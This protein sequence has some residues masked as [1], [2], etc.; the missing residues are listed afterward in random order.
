MRYSPGEHIHRVVSRGPLLILFLLLLA[1]PHADI[2]VSAHNL[3]SIPSSGSR[4]DLGSSRPP[5]GLVYLR[6]PKKSSGN[7]LGSTSANSS[8][9]RPVLAFYYPWYNKKDWC[10][11]HMSDLPTIQYTSSDNATIERQLQWAKQAS[12][13]GFI[14]SWW[15]P[16]DNTDKNF[17]K[18][19]QDAILLKASTGYAFTSSLYI[20]SDAPAL[21][22]QAKM[23]AGL[24]YIQEKYSNKSLFFHWQTKPVIFFWNPLGNG[25]SLKFWEDIRRQVD[26]QHKMLW[27]AEGVDMKLL[28]VFDGIHLFSAGYWGILHHTMK[29]VDQGFRNQISTYN[30][31]HHTHK[32]WAAGV[33]PGYNDTRVPGRTGTYIVPRNNGATYRTS[34]EAALASKPDWITITSF[35]EWF[36]GAMIEPSV[37]YHTL[38]LDITRQYAK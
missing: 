9:H 12:I 3:V 26:P 16:G 36:E 20:E 27:S 24:R 31:I 19:Q 38:Y 35:N 33:L 13:T 7:A 18:L 6:N 5:A 4:K 10:L 17:V 11:C 14:S 15:G 30:T 29:Q 2:S 25:R 21:K 8:T 22:T 34:W 37:H 1:F 32:I 28:D 23:V